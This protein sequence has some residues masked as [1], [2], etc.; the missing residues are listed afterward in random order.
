VPLTANKIAS[1]FYSSSSVDKT[2]K[3]LPSEFKIKAFTI[4][5]TGSSKASKEIVYL[6][7]VSS[8]DTF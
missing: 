3:N 5:I 2:L 6:K 1:I 7:S 4:G 8:I